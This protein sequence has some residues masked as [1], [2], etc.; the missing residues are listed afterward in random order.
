MDSVRS[1][2]MLKQREGDGVKLLFAIGPDAED[3]RRMQP[4]ELQAAASSLRATDTVV[5]SA[6]LF[7]IIVGAELFSNLSSMT[8]LPNMLIDAIQGA[9]LSAYSVIVLM[10]VIYFV[11]GMF[12]DSLGMI[13]L[14]V[15]VFYP[16]IDF[17][18]F[19]LIWF[20]IIV[21]TVTEISLITPPIGM[22]I[23]IMRSMNR[24]LPLGTIYMG[25]LPF[26]AADLVRLAILVAFPAIA[27]VLPSMMG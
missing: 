21:V 15:P 20:G 26:V 7:I 16:V 22:N 23:F 5:T 25:V 3:N 11:M 14:T 13:L 6:M 18:G 8:G 17:L 2:P 1:L 12:L 24:D 19:D 27:L 9:G 4:H 10:L